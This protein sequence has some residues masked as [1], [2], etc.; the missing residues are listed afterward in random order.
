MFGEVNSNKSHFEMGLRDITETKSRYRDILTRS[1]TRRLK[2]TEYQ[3][4]FK[5]DREYIKTVI[6]FSR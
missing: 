2:P 1:I 5:P 3:Q 4:V 6:G